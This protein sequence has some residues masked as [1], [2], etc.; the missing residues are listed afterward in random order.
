MGATVM[1]DWRICRVAGDEL[2]QLGQP[3][4]AAT[5]GR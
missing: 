5:S 1:A 4:Q 2:M 3:A